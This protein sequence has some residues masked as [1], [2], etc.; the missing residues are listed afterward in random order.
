ML[1]K[2]TD[3]AYIADLLV[4]AAKAAAEN[5]YVPYSERATGAAILTADGIIYG[6][7]AVEVGVFSASICAE[8]AAIASAVTAGETQFDA[9]AVYS[10]GGEPI[11]PCGLCMETIAEFVKGIVVIAA[12]DEKMDIYYIEDIKNLGK[13]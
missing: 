3:L 10:F 5:A 9:V 12:C 2:D 11:C 1:D 8:R 6:G 4:P 7:A 13:K